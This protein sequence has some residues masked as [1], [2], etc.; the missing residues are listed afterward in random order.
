MPHDLTDAVRRLHGGEPLWVETVTVSETFQGATA[1]TR[2]V[3]TFDLGP[4]AAARRAFAWA[5]PVADSA[6]V[7]YFAVLQ[8]GPIETARDAV[9]ASLLA[10]RNG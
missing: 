9:R 2:E 5:E 3:S 4:D 7:R 6:R 8:A 10:D 1:W